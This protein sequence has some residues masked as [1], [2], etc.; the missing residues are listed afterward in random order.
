MSLQTFINRLRV[1]RAAS[2]DSPRSWRSGETPPL[3]AIGILARPSPPAATWRG[4][5]HLAKGFPVLQSNSAITLEVNGDEAF[6][7]RVLDPAFGRAAD[8]TTLV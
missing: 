2:T 1:E 6:A 7:Y 4:A 3:D 8:R 5:A